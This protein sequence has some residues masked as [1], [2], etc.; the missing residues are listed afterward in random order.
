[1]NPEDFNYFQSRVS[2]FISGSSSRPTFGGIG[3]SKITRLSGLIPRR[4]VPSQVLA[5]PS[6]SLD[7]DAIAPRGVVSSLGRLTLNLEVINNNLDRIKEIIVNDYKETQDTNKKEIEDY[8]KRIAN[9][10]RIFGKKELGDKKTDV[11]GAVRKYV[12]SFF[13]GAGG[14]IRSLAAFNLMQGILSGDPS[15]ILGPLLGIGLTYLPAIGAG[16]GSA[17]AGSLITRLFSGGAAKGVSSAAESVAGAGRFSG[18]RGLAG[19]AALVGGGI[20]LA[21]SIFNNPEESTQQ[22]LEN[23]TQQQKGLADPKNLVPIPQDDLKRFERLNKKFEAALDFI[24]GNK[25]GTEAA[26]Y[27]QSTVG[28]GGGGGAGGG[29]GPAPSIDAS[30]RGS[31]PGQQF[32]NGQLI[33]LAKSVGA[34]DEEAVRLAAIAKYESGGR[35]GAFRDRPDTGDLSYGLWQINMLGSLGPNRLKQFG[36]SSNEQLFDPVTNAQAALATLRSSGWGSWSTNSKVTTSDLQEGRRNLKNLPAASSIPPTP[37]TLPPPAQVNIPVVT[38][39]QNTAAPSRSPRVS[40]PQPQQMPSINVVPTLISQ[41]ES[42]ETS[43]SPEANDNTPS[44]NT[45][46]PE[47]FLALYSKLIYQIV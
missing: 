11:L 37:P 23:L 27:P 25:K 46:H 7:D 33:S 41:N 36:I 2:R 29:T 18:F 40:A 17:V 16:I 30:L 45:T 22:R 9:R 31:V 19:R 15:K 10:G 20:A 12:G 47:N 14:A 24:L 43:S 4:S 42:P 5:S 39:S 32:S 34:T 26:N 1:M 28:G 13:S 44:I 3:S 8:R 21:N 6:S 35:S 38:V